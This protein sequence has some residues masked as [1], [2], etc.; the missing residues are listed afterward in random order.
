MYT[1][2][3]F[4]KGSTLKGNNLLSKGK[5]IIFFKV[6]PFQEGMQKK[7]TNKKKKNNKKKKKKKKKKFLQLLPLR[8]YPFRF[9]PI[10]RT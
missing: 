6:D 10:T 4:K 5:Q 2:I 7:K 1:P 9:S 3:P 8:V